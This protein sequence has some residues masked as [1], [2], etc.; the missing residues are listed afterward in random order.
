[1]P[2]EENF[3]KE[4]GKLITRMQMLTSD[5]RNV[6]NKYVSFRTQPAATMHLQGK[7]LEVLW[8]M[9]QLKFNVEMG[10]NADS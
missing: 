10:K 9:E 8:W 2:N 6:T 7:L 4:L 5:I 3:P 1:M